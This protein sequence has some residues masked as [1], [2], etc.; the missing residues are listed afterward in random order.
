MIVVG[1]AESEVSFEQMD[2]EL[3]LADIDAD[4]DQGKW[5]GHG[6]SVLLNSG[7]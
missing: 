6:Y 5:F 2:V 4:V 1:N 7:S 3:V